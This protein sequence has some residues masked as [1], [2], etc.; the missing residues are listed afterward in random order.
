MSPPVWLA[1]VGVQAFLMAGGVTRMLPLTGITLPLV[2]YGGSSMMVAWYWLVAHISADADA[3]S[4]LGHSAEPGLA[5]DR[6][7]WGIAI[8][9][10]FR[11]CRPDSPTGASSALIHWRHAKTILIDR[12]RS[13]ASTVGGS[14][15]TDTVLAE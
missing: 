2:S 12:G 5:A 7:G 11:G 1:A 14:S 3:T 9:A 8:L 10:N 15:I 4:S 6:N 13:A